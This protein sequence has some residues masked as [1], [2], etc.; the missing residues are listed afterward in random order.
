VGRK[1]IIFTMSVNDDD[2][3]NGSN[4]EHYTNHKD[5]K[6]GNTNKNTLYSHNYIKSNMTLFYL[7]LIHVLL[8]PLQHLMK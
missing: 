2:N 5:I 8:F 3:K 6:N 4:N 1:L 7:M